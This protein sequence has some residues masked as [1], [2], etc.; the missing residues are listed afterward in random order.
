MYNGRYVAG[1]EFQSKD[2]DSLGD[3]DDDGDIPLVK[4]WI[5]NCQ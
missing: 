1:G 5:N 4:N 3:A 2:S